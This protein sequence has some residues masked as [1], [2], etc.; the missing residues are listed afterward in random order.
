MNNNT[1]AFLTSSE[2]DFEEEV[3]AWSDPDDLIQFEEAKE[4]EEVPKQ[5]LRK[6]PGPY[7]LRPIKMKSELKSPK[8]KKRLKRI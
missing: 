7:S 2:E 1:F 5:K 3:N 4:E 8:S 6:R